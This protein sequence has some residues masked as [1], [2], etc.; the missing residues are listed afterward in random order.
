MLFL[1]TPK[2]H[3]CVSSIAVCA[4]LATACVAYQP[5]DA[6]DPVPAPVSAPVPGQPLGL[7]AA[8][9]HALRHNPEL[10]ALAADARAA[11]ADLPGLQGQGE[12]RSSSDSLALMVDPVALLGLGQRAREIAAVDARAAAAVAALVAAR[13]R[14]IGAVAEAFAVAAALQE[15][16]PLPTAIDPAPFAAAGLAAPIAVARLQAAERSAIAATAVRAAAQRD[17]ERGLCR[18]LGLAATTALALEPCPPIAAPDRDEAALLHRPD[19]RLAHAEW[20]AADAAF[21]QAVADQY[22]AVMVGPEFPLR[23]DPLELMGWLRLPLFATGPANAA[24]ERRVAARARWAAAWQAAT[25][26]AASAAAADDAARVQFAAAAAAADQ[27]RTALAVATVGL[28]VEVDAFAAYADALAMAVRDGG[29]L[30]DA[31]IAAAR[32]R[33]RCAVA[34]GWPLGEVSP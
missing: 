5:D 23:G 10:Q 20:L 18:L 15:L 7:A 21:R 28:D 31:A 29:E 33:V 27:S 11:G 22:P 14:T 16:P 25:A 26:D 13:W 9:E 6:N 17:N 1:L 30:R 19:V 8:I 24:R 2:P 4:L 3:P 34:H 12:Y 32:A